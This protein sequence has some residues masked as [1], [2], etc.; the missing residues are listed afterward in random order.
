MFI[1]THAHFDICMADGYT[2]ENL[3][4]K[5]KESNVEYS[6][7]I[8]VDRN[9]FLL[10]SEFASRHENVFFT[11][12]IHPSSSFEDDDIACLENMV[13][14]NKNSR[15]IGVGETGL[16]YHWMEHEKN[17][18]IDLFEK[19][20]DIAVKN[21][22]AVIVH[23]RDAMD[24]TIAV[25]KNMHPEK[26]I[27]HCFSGNPEE[28]EMLAGMGYFISFA[29]NLTYKKADN[30]HEA[31][32]RVPVD[33]LL[34][35]TDCPYLAPVPERGKKNRPDFVVYTYRFA[36]EMRNMDVGKLCE[37]VKNNFSRLISKQL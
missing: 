32:K 12:G 11:L 35:E 24:D 7:Q 4:L 31:V 5:M 37:T 23:S 16:D 25:L 26:V 30:L 8:G 36:A 22:L 20:I 21:D 19:Q 3:L 27:I 17:I 14:E 13:S 9:D 10:T 29:G 15:L 2:E 18:Q 6:V 33:N 34:F 1:D 28:A